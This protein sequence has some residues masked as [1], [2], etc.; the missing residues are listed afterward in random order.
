MR[1]HLLPALLLI[2]ISGPAIAAPAGRE[3]DIA[4]GAYQ[5]G[6]YLKAF[7]AATDRVARDPTDA[8]A[9][10][11]LGELYNQGLG[12]AGDPK[13]AAEWYRLAAARGDAHALLSLGLMALDGRGVP[14]DPKQGRAWLE[15]AAAKGEP[16]AC[17]NVALLNLATGNEADLQKAVP[18]LRKAADAEIADAQH[19]LGVL[20]LQGRGVARDPA[21]AARWFSRAAGNGSV[22]GLVEHAILLFNG[23]GIP[24]D[25]TAAAKE[26]LRAAAQG[27][28]IAQNRLARLYAIGRGVPQDKAEAAAWHMVAAAQ[29]LSDTWLDDALRE[30]TADERARAERLA[31]ERSRPY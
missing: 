17:Y 1:H 9:M 27:N 4:F 12:I 21:E 7:Q 25:E 31:A 22:A 10:T 30:L 11:L 15:Q 28:A 3:P 8:P 5:R 20:H 29:G 23:E 18:L 14:K 16:S 2:G 6:L 24:A 13:R 26:F 19:A